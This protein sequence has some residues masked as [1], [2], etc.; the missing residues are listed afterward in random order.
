MVIRV[1]D[2]PPADLT[3]CPVRPIGFPIDAEATMPPAVRAAA[4]RLAQAY[5]ATVDQLERLIAWTA[6]APCASLAPKDVAR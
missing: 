1:K 6:P 2:T 5:A 3:A 4:I